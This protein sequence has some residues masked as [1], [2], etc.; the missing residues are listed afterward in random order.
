MLTDFIE[1]P[2]DTINCRAC[3]RDL[4]ALFNHFDPASFSPNQ[5]P[6]YPVD[7]WMPAT[8]RATAF[9]CDAYCSQAWHESVK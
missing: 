1:H 6:E 2:G 9:F 7:Y 8:G 5:A 4:T 3:G